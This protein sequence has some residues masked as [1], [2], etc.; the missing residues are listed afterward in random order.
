[1]KI[2][3]LDSNHALLLNQLNDVGFVNEQDYTASKEIIAAK[4]HQYDGIIIRSRFTIDKEF[5][6]KATNLKFIGRVGAGLENIDC[7]YANQK[8]IHLISAPEGNRNAV[9]EHALGM[10]LSLFNKFKKADT[11]VRNGKWLREDNRGIELDGKTVG[12]I[13]YG[14]MGKSFAKKLRGF[15]V[16]VLCYDIKPNVGDENCTQV[17]LEE[18]QQKADVLS[19]HTPQTTLT[20]NMIDADF[21]NAFSKPFWLLNTAR[22]KSVVTSDLVEALKSAKILGAGLDVLEYEKKSFENLFVNQEMPEAFQY[23]IKADNVLLSPHVAGWTVES[24]QKL[25]QTIVDKIKAL[26]C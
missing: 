15:D 12:L 23:L 2:L 26:F 24:K 20:T 19:L 25:A 21:I 1:M 10:I 22:G 13:G 7:E 18:L 16:K 6:D 3:H 9:G 14:N 8:G 4:I 5:L 11:E 17:S